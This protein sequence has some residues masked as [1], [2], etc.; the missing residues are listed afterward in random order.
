MDGGTTKEIN[1][2]NKKVTSAEQ[3]T[4]EKNSR[5]KAKTDGLSWRKFKKK[6]KIDQIKSK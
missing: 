5:K 3:K 6:E 4:A 1:K 2:K